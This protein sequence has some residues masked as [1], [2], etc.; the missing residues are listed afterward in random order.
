MKP[1]FKLN[2]V[3]TNVLHR[4]RADRTRN[5]RQVFQPVPTLRHTLLNKAVPVFPARRLNQPGV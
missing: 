5:Q 1:F 3:G 2:P 4:R